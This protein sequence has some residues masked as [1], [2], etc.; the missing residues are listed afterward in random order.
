MRG[1]SVTGTEGKNWREEE[2]VHLP[3]AT[4]TTIPTAKSLCDLEKMLPDEAAFVGDGLVDEEVAEVCCVDVVR[5]LLP[6]RLDEAVSLEA[7]EVVVGASVALLVAAEE[8]EVVSEGELAVSELEEETPRLGVERVVSEAVV[9]A[10]VE[11]AAELDE[12]A[13]VTAATTGVATVGTT[14][15]GVLT[16]AAVALAF[17]TAGTLTTTPAPA[18]APALRIAVGLA[19]ACRTSRSRLQR[20]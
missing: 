14:A 10:A 13:A 1:R 20:L 3:M 11:E 9:L 8:E 4:M 18:P 16:E 2:Y 19:M 5:L 17:T 6:P 12:S 7:E 15:T